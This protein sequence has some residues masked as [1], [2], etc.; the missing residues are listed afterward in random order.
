LRTGYEECSSVDE[1]LASIARHAPR[2]VIFDVEPLV[3]YWDTDT[4]TLDDGIARF[5]GRMVSMPDLEVI[6][7]ATNSGRRPSTMPCPPGIRV[8]YQASAL[9]PLRRGLFGALPAPG[10][11]VGDQVATDGVLAHR[12]GYTFLRYRGEQQRLPLGPRVMGLLG[13]PLRPLLFTS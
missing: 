1:A 7:F 11:I 3:A 8:I 2:T 12:L 4:P 10:L 6:A 5:V 13:L 9:K